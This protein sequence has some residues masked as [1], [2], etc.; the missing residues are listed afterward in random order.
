MTDVT[1]D[2]G[3]PVD[4]RVAGTVVGRVG[5][6]QQRQQDRIDVASLDLFSLWELLEVV[7]CC[8]AHIAKCIHIDG[9]D[10]HLGD[11]ASKE[12]VKL[13]VLLGVHGFGWVILFP[14]KGP[15]RRAGHL[16]KQRRNQTFWTYIKVTA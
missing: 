16:Q 3:R 12:I 13:G 10:G 15:S 11:K 1:A 4:P 2:G 7:R 6:G 5:V 14:R 8:L 9:A